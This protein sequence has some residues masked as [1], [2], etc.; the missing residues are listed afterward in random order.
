MAVVNPFGSEIKNPF[1]TKE[2]E[3]EKVVNPFKDKEVNKKACWR[4]NF[5]L[6]SKFE[7]K[8]NVPKIIVTIE[9]PKKEESISLYKNCTPTGMNIKIPSIICRIPSVKKT[10]L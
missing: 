9:A 5:L 6:W 10:V 7:R 1:K 4:F 3:E 8:N 2:E